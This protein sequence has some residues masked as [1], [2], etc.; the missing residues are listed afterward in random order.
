MAAS[1]ESMKGKDTKE[2]MDWDFIQNDVNDDGK[3]F[4]LM[5]KNRLNKRGIFFLDKNYPIGVKG[6]LILELRIM[7][8]LRCQCSYNCSWVMRYNN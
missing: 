1:D 3:G 6:L 8:L 5:L 2:K 7:L 4:G